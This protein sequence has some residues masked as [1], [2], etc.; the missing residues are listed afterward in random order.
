M[1]SARPASTSTAPPLRLTRAT[2]R[3]SASFKRA[4]ELFTGTVGQGSHFETLNPRI[5]T[6]WGPL[7]DPDSPFLSIPR[8]INAAAHGEAPDLV[9]SRPAG[10]ADDGGDRCYVKDCARAIA[11]LLTS[12][13]LRHDT[14]NVSSGRPVFNREFVDAINMVLPDARVEL[15]AGR[16]PAAPARDPYLD[17]SRLTRPPASSRDS[18]SRTA[19]RTTSAGFVTAMTDS[20]E[21]ERL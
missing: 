7:F 12:P 17:I 8:L 1:R 11:L 18:A 3:A 2:G 10:F 19:S 21:P 5:G 4:A 15:P 9:P 6:V 13:T 20:R 14:N 16:S